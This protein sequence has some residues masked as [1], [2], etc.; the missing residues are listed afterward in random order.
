MFPKCKL[1]KDH[2]CLSTYSIYFHSSVNPIQAYTVIRKK[3]KPMTLYSERFVTH[4]F[5]WQHYHCQICSS[6]V[7]GQKLICLCSLLL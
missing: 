5:Q 7:I 6:Q 2:A 4:V 1:T 3:C